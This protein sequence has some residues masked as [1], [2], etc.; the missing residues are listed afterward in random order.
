MN[1]CQ[2]RWIDDQGNPTPDPNPAIARVRTIA[3]V[4]QIGGRGIKLEAS[5]WFYICAEHAKRLND[6]GMHIWECEALPAETAA[7]KPQAYPDREITDAEK[8]RNAGGRHG[9][10][11]MID[12]NCDQCIQ[13]GS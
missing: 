12:R 10:Y 7:V 9:H 11:G 1:T 2:I 3:H 13:D 4:A 5:D 8:R 6:R